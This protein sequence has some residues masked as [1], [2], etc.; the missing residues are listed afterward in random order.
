M[1]PKINILFIE[2]ERNILTFVS[3]LLY[4]HN[5][6]ITTAT[7]GTEGLHLISSICP[8]LI[9]LDLGLPDMDGQT[10][11]QEVR[12]WSACPIIVI[13]A[14]TNE[15]EK[16]KAL[17]LGAD[18]YITKPFGSAELL[19]RIRTSLRHSNS[20][21]SSP[22]SFSHLYKYDDLI[23]N[24]EKR[25]LTVNGALIHLTPIEYKILAF[26]AQNCGKVMTYSSIITNVWGPYA[27][28]DNR[29][30]RVNMANIRR[31]IEVNPAQPKYIFT[32]VGVG[33]RM[34]EDM[35]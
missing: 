17:D 31:K 32:E 26:L 5:Y 9:L 24:F 19:A 30:L 25:T 22:N 35:C 20:L 7:T 13:S 11:I 15:R 33:Y 4:T 27:D 8:D 28:N 6:K 12:K 1:Q 16:V 29:I 2:D 34:N 10:I 21:A 18:D 23:L 3:K 14:R